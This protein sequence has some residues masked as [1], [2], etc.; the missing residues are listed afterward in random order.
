MDNKNNKL[1]VFLTFLCISPLIL[2]VTIYENFK[3]ANVYTFKE[4]CKLHTFNLFSIFSII[5]YYLNLLIR[6]IFNISS[7]N[8]LRSIMSSIFF[9]F[10]SCIILTTLNFGIKIFFLTSILISLTFILIGINI[11]APKQTY[12]LNENNI[13][14]SFTYNKINYNPKNFFS[15]IFTLSGTILFS[16]TLIIKVLFPYLIVI[17]IILLLIPTCIY[18]YQLYKY[19]KNKELEKL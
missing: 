15:N 2:F 10:I 17:L 19:S 9:I 12:Y 3:N 8:P 1:I 13:D 5:F 18:F 11:S 7:N 16:I 4:K 6:I 14:N